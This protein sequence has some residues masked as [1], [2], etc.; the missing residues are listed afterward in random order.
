M[1]HIFLNEEVVNDF[2]RRLAGS[3]PFR[4]GTYSLYADVPVK[5]LVSDAP[6]FTTL[7][8]LNTMDGRTANQTLDFVVTHGNQAIL[9][10]T[11]EVM[12][13]ASRKLFSGVLSPLPHVEVLSGGSAKQNYH[14]LYHKVRDRLEEY[15]A[16]PF[17][18]FLLMPIPVE[19][20]QQEL[21]RMHMLHAKGTVSPHGRACGL[22]FQYTVNSEDGTLQRQ[23]FTSSATH[24]T[25]LQTVNWESED[26]DCSALRK[27]LDTPIQKLFRNHPAKWN[28]L[29]HIM[30][31]LSKLQSY[32][33]GMTVQNFG[34]FP[35]LVQQLRCRVEDGNEDSKLLMHLTD[36]LL[37]CI[38]DVLSDERTAVRFDI[39]RA[40]LQEYY[41]AAAKY[42]GTCYPL[43]LYNQSIRPFLNETVY[44]GKSSLSDILLYASY[45]PINTPF[46]ELYELLVAPLYTT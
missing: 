21:Q 13:S 44:P 5:C 26:T 39:L 41:T 23:I 46:P 8:N 33:A 24:Q 20:S 14:R 34:D 27:L 37:I 18:T 43:W 31:E 11:T 3:A 2:A 6:Y 1:Y 16:H 17:V 15:E 28:T 19:Q 29:Q 35:D 10:I 38:S 40:P 42:S 22:F 7:K 25:F 36:E 12:A 4:D 30:S 9:G 45:L 32:P